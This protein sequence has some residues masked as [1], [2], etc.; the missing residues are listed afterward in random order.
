MSGKIVRAKLSR[1]IGSVLKSIKVEFKSRR[2]TF[3]DVSKTVG[4]KP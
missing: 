3:N 2:K 1:Q 4:N